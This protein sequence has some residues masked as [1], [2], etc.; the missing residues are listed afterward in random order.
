LVRSGVARLGEVRRGRES[1]TALVTADIHLTDKARDDYRWG[2]FS[3]LRDQAEKEEAS[4]VLILGDITDA[5]DRHNAK[6]VNRLTDS[7]AAV[8]EVARVILLRGNHDFLDP[9]NPFFRF[10]SYLENVVYVSSNRVL[11]LS[12]GRSLFVPAGST[13]DGTVFA[14]D[15]R[16]LFAHTTFAGSEAENGTLLPGIDPRI[17]RESFKGACYSGD[18]HV[19][20]RINK[21]IE[22]IGAPY[23]IK[24]GDRYKPRVLVIGNNGKTSDL[25]YPAPKKHVVDI[26]RPEELDRLKIKADDQVKVRCYL[27]RADYVK[28][29]DIRQEIRDIAEQKGWQLFGP[30]LVPLPVH[31]GRKEEA[32]DRAVLSPKELLEAYADKQRASDDHIEIGSELLEAVQR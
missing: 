32:P 17:L 23:H 3:W 24:F 6:L 12:I 21:Q 26:D 22:Y 2:L 7:I 25:Y 10:T 1:M 27:R 31:E 9:D 19:P 20:Q 28:W 16:Y 11:K 8:S 5:K 15:I 14:N 18:I 29:R 4:E 13:W 30:E